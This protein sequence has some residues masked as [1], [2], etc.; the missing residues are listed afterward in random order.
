M[1]TQLLFLFRFPESPQFHFSQFWKCNPTF[2]TQLNAYKEMS[3]CCLDNA[4][5]GTISCPAGW[6]MIAWAGKLILR[7]EAP[8]R[9]VCC[10]YRK[11]R[12]GCG[13]VLLG[14]GGAWGPCSVYES[15]RFCV[16]LQADVWSSASLVVVVICRWFELLGLMNPMLIA[17]VSVCCPLLYSRPSTSAAVQMKVR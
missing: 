2:E 4:C 1:S 3:S 15:W 6:W 14:A 7:G 12:L 8:N 17:V 9:A 5:T 16:A 10:E 11:Y 13:A